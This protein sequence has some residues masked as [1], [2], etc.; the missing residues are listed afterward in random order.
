MKFSLKELGD[1]VERLLGSAEAQFKAE[2][3]ELK[4]NVSAAITGIETQ[5]TSAKDSLASVATAL[6]AALTSA[7]VEVKAD[8]TPADMVASLSGK[9]TALDSSLTTVNTE[10]ANAKSAL[11]KHLAALPGHADYKEGGAKAG[12]TLA[13]LITAEQNATNTA[14]AA[15]GVKIEQLPAGGKQPE[16]AATGKPKNL[17]EACIAAKKAGKA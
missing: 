11:L 16:A 12:A 15:S 13:E 4:N 3:T 10:I 14:I 5:L 2:L 7:K 9:I 8:A 1:K 6:R 17:T